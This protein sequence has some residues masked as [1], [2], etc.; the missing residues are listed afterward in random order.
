MTRDEAK[1]KGLKTYTGRP[2]TCGSQEKYVSSMSCVHCTV[3]R[4]IQKLYDAELMAPYRTHLKAKARLYR[5]RKNHPAQVAEQWK[6]QKPNKKQYYQANKEQFRDDALRRAYG[7][8]SLDYQ[9]LLTEQNNR[10]AICGVDKCPTGKRFAVDHDHKTNLIRGL[11][12]K[13]CNNGL[14][15]FNDDPELLV[16]AVVY[17]R[18][19]NG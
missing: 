7:I 3:E 1:E 12:C 11:L 6:R 2:H 14:G 9:E 10:C 17:L 16:K 8:T 4:S 13:Q 19:H 5:W 15:H 18:S